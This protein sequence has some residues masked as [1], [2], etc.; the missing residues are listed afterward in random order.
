[1]LTKD[2]Y[3]RSMTEAG[4]AHTEEILRR[5]GWNFDWEGDTIV[6]NIPMDDDELFDFIFGEFE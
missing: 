3:A 1:M 6:A 5:M 4:K 2:I